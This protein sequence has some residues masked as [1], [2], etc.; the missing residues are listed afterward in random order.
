MATNHLGHFLLTYLLIDMLKKSAPS[1]IVNVSS[2]GHLVCTD[3]LFD[4]FNVKNRCCGLSQIYAYARSKA[5]NVLFTRELGK[6]FS[7]NH[8]LNRK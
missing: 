6:R 1:R 3:M 2:L 8:N 4:D 5:A 7:S